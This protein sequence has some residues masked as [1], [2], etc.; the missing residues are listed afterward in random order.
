VDSYLLHNLL[1]KRFLKSL[2]SHNFQSIC[3]FKSLRWLSTVSILLFCTIKF[4]SHFL[5]LYYLLLLV[6]VLNYFIYLGSR[7][8][9]QLSFNYIFIM[10]EAHFSW[11][12]TS[13]H[14]SLHYFC[15]FFQGGYS[16]LKLGII[17]VFLILVIRLLN[18]IEIIVVLII[19]LRSLV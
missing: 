1:S 6:S 12:F 2:L 8:L 7:S 4:G 13:N 19:F 18:F 9:T 17:D 15:P 16:L 3:A 5:L 11:I 14:K 10:R